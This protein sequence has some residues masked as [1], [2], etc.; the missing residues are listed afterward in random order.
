M[1]VDLAS[2]DGVSRVV[3]LD[4]SGR[5]DGK[6]L[7]T[8]LVVARAKPDMVVAMEKVFFHVEESKLRFEDLILH[9]KRAVE[10]VDGEFYVVAER[11]EFFGQ[12][13][14]RVAACLEHPF[15]YA[16]SLSEK[17][18]VGFAHEASHALRKLCT[19]NRWGW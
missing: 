8:A 5:H 12:P 18:L 9:L 14:W 1:W 15:K 6:P 11:G 16:E 3:A 4:T 2:G 7:V 13:E 10:K 19:R 17:I